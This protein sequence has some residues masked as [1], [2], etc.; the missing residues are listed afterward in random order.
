MKKIIYL[1]TLSVLFACSE[2]PKKQEK[3]EAILTEGKWQFNLSLSSEEKLPVDAVLSKKEDQYQLEFINAE[4]HFLVSDVSIDH[5]KIM[6]KDPVFNSWFEGEI[7]SSDKIK[8]F[9]YKKDTTYK[10]PFE[11]MLGTKPRFP[12]LNPSNTEQ[13]DVSG[14]WEVDFSK[15]EPKDHYKSIGQFKQEG[16]LLSGTFITETGDYRFLQGNVYGNQFFMSCF[17][18]SHAFLFKATLGEGDTLKGKFWS[19]TK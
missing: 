11:A 14:K 2:A 16:N 4:E 18:G 6:I 10:V 8:G 9:W 1:I 3:N 12:E 19:G 7:T 5:K 15:S 13:V 17:D